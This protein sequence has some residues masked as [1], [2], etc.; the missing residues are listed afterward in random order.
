[1]RRAAGDALRTKVDPALVGR[2]AHG[3]PRV[4]RTTRH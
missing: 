1:L 2:L 4:Q 3:Q